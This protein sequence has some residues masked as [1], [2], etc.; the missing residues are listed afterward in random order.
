MKHSE[1]TAIN[2]RN[3]TWR[4]KKFP[5]SELYSRIF[6]EANGIKLTTTCTAH[7]QEAVGVAGKANEVINN[8]VGKYQVWIYIQCYWCMKFSFASDLFSH[9][10]QVT[11]RSLRKYIQ[12]GIF[13]LKALKSLEMKH[14]M[15]SKCYY[16]QLTA[17]KWQLKCAFHIYHLTEST[18]KQSSCMFWQRVNVKH[19]SWCIIWLSS[20]TKKFKKKPLQ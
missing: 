18:Q 12:I 8:Y 10:G 2:Q 1:L 15:K 3:D 19:N 14:Y 9:F 16:L 11:H 13:A 17:F 7:W 6:P 4:M 5:I 20:M